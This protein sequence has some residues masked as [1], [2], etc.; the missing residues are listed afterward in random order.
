MSLKS[1]RHLV[2]LFFLLTFRQIVS[3][4]STFQDRPY[5]SRPWRASHD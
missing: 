3:T 5:G 2:L 1:S 4:K